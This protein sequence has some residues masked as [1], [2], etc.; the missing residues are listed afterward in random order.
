V[1]RGAAEGVPGVRSEEDGQG[2]YSAHDCTA[3]SELHA[4]A[5]PHALSAQV[6]A[7]ALKKA[8]GTIGEKL[9]S[10]QLDDMIKDAVPPSCRA[11]CQAVAKLFQSCYTKPLQSRCKAVT[12]EQASEPVGLP[13][14]ES[15]PNSGKWQ[16]AAG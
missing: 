11:S 13:Q 3:G 12:N 10:S 1:E 5:R 7:A 16:I 15:W 8:L 4:R 6:D 9:S 2:R 14:A